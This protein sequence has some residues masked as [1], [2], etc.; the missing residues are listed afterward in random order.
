MIPY[1][2]I[3]DIAM[4]LLQYLAIIGIVAIGCL[5][6]L[7]VSDFRTRLDQWPTDRF[8]VNYLLLIGVIAVGQMVVIAASWQV[9]HIG[10]TQSDPQFRALRLIAVLTVYPI[11]VLGLGT[12]SVRLYCWQRS[13]EQWLTLRTIAGLGVATGLYIVMLIGAA[14]VLFIAA[15]FFALPT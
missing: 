4:T 2:S 3:G 1:S 11:T 10:S 13:I 7:A 14:I 12:I 8:L 15:L 6:S 9:M 5:P